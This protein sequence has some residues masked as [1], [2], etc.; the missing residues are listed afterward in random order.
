VLSSTQFAELEHLSNQ[1]VGNVTLT[2]PWEGVYPFTTSPVNSTESVNPVYF[3][4]SSNISSTSLFPSIS[5]YEHQN[6]PFPYASRSSNHTD[7]DSTT[8]FHL[9]SFPEAQS[10]N[11]ISTGFNSSMIPSVSSSSLIPDSWFTETVPSDPVPGSPISNTISTPATSPSTSISNSDG[12]ISCTWPDCN[13][14]FGS[15]SHYNHHCKNHTRPHP[16]RECPARLATTRLLGRHVNECHSNSEKYYCVIPT[17]KQS[18]V[19]GKHFKREDNCKRHMKKIHGLTTR[20]CDMDEATREIRRKR[21]R[22]RRC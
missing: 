17:C 21:Q 9:Y 7:F 16:C 11:T 3:P 20:D 1:S 12:L 6:L 13:K 18:R 5:D 19:G 14:T 8:D 15:T 4:T 10:E 2:H 22:K